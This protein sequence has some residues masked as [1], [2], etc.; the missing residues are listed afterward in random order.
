MYWKLTK[1]YNVDTG[2]DGGQP[3]ASTNDNSGD[4]EE[5][6]FTPAQQA[7][8][9]ALIDK[10]FAKGAARAAKAAEKDKQTEADKLATDRA[11][12]EAEKARFKVQT[13]LSKEGYI[14][15]DDSDTA[16]IGLFATAPDA[17]ESNITAL[18]KLIDAKVNEEVDKRLKSA[19]QSAPKS[20]DNSV[21]VGDA[22]NGLFRK[23]K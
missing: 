5:L 22:I 10:A 16:L 20:G 12:L 8:I 6:P 15:G 14:L 2:A 1:F 23:V 17:A 4:G 21:S 19:G 11:E 18:K 7:K 3:P 13:L 9:D